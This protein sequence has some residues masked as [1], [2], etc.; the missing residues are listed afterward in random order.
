MVNSEQ[1]HM[2]FIILYLFLRTFDEESATDGKKIKYTVEFAGFSFE[3]IIQNHI[4]YMVKSKIQ[5]CDF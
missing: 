3:H 4:L 5:N 2:S 1:L